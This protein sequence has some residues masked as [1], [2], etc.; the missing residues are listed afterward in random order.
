MQLAVDPGHQIERV[1]TLL[2]D[3]QVD[4]AVAGHVASGGG[5]EE[6]NLLPLGY[7]YNAPDD[8]VQR[9]L[10]KSEFLQGMPISSETNIV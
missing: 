9:L 2:D 8:V 5:S 1:R 10:V 4:V 7:L 6:D 3:E